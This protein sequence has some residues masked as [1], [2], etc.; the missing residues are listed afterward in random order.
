MGTYPHTGSVAR[1]MAACEQC[2]DGWIG[3]VATCLAC[4]CC[5]L[6]IPTLYSPILATV[7]WLVLG[8][9]QVSGLALQPRSVVLPCDLGDWSSVIWRDIG[10]V[11]GGVTVRS[12]STSV[13]VRS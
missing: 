4:Q 7:A 5:P 8:V 1:G 3:L 12:S 13:T 6:Q 9:R 10:L 2:W 11:V